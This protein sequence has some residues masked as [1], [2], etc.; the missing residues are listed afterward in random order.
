MA[1]R[2]FTDATGT[3]WQVYDVVPRP[4]ERRHYDRR[5]PTG[6]SAVERRGDE[7]RRLTVGRLSALSD[8]GLGWLC[9]DRGDQRRRLAPIPEAWAQASEAELER[10]LGIARPVRRVATPQP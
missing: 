1:L 3:E 9:F 5:T 10:Y 4:E 8:L 7:D 6:Q 2:T